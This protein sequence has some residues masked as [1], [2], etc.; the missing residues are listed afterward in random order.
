MKRILLLIS[1]YLLTIS[2]NAQTNQKWSATG[3]FG[4]GFIV[5][6][7]PSVVHV[8]QKHSRSF[9]LDYT[10]KTSRKKGWEELYNFPEIG[11]G[12]QYFDLGNP[13]ELGTA[14]GLFGL[15]KFGLLERKKAIL[16][17]HLG[18]G[19]GYISRPFNLIDNY[20]NLLAGSH[21]NATI[22][23]GL[24]YCIKISEKTNFITGINLT[25]YSNGGSKV[26]NM[27]INLAALNL[28]IKYHFFP[29]INEPKDT[30]SIIRKQSFEMVS[31]VGFKQI[32]PPSSPNYVVGIF[33]AD[34]IWPV[35][36]KSMITAG[37]DAFID[38]SHKAYLL[39][40]SI[41]TKG[42]EGY[43]RS[44]IHFGYGLQVGKCSGI[45]QTGYYF[46]N[47]FDI[48]GHIYSILSFRY[49]INEHVFACF[50]LKSHYA[51]AD[52][53]QYGIGYHF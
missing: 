49:H 13:Q 3:K 8:L 42:A 38:K 21:L 22:T 14:Q 6:H 48:D 20:K 36:N 46:Y 32:Y 7:R 33:T 45:L 16:K 37:A 17:V 35:K 9:E 11:I 52:Y 25:H 41:I 5:A 12:Y 24:E 44:G 47:P 4:D 31:A 2:T 51:R 19:I 27:G 43:L 15:I 18:L 28:G 26:P 53:F 29:T 50:N 1:I 40:D 39:R 34:Y 23:S 30:F 10:Y